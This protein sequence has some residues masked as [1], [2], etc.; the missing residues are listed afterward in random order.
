MVEEINILN[1]VNFFSKDD[2]M[3][4]EERKHFVGEVKLYRASNHLDSKELKTFFVTFFNGARTSLHYHDT[5]QILIAHEGVGRV[6]VMTG[7]DENNDEKIERVI[8]NGQSVLIPP[9]KIHWHGAK[10][11][12]KKFSHIAILKAGGSTVWL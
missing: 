9:G 8:S 2:D 10:E 6:T 12:E 1:R 5:E 4:E 11:D 7:I 3:T